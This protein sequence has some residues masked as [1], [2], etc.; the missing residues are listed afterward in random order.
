[1][2]SISKEKEDK[3]TCEAMKAI[4]AGEFYYDAITH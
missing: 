4:K 2:L 3:K 1:M